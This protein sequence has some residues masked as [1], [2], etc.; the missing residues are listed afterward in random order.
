MD[1]ALKGLF[2]T[3]L[4]QC[5]DGLRGKVKNR[6]D[7]HTL[8]RDGDTINLAKNIEEEGYSL[9]KSDYPCITAYRALIK[10][11]KNIHDRDGARPTGDH[12]DGLQATADLLDRA[13]GSTEGIPEGL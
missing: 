6:S 7:F 10:H 12:L 13:G 11:S 1:A 3:L 2:H 9:R 8:E 4:G 5:D